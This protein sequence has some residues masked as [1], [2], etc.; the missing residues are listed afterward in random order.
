MHNLFKFL[1]LTFLIILSGCSSRNLNMSCRTD[2]DCGEGKF[3]WSTMGGGK[4]CQVKTSYEPLS[5]PKFTQKQISTGI[6]CKTDTDCKKAEFCWSVMGKVE[7]ECQA[8]LPSNQ[9]DEKTAK[10]TDQKEITTNVIREKKDGIVYLPNDDKPFTGKYEF[11]DSKNQKQTDSYVNGLF[12]DK[13]GN[14]SDL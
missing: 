13:D 6:S 12:Q 8:R 5:I 9:A 2:S 4:E 11:F 7:K 14:V 3:C 10:N 1:F